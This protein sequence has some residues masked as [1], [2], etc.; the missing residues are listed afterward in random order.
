MIYTEKVGCTGCRYCMPC[1]RGVD[2]PE[3]FLCYNS[4]YTEG[5]WDGRMEFAQNVGLRRQPALATQCIG[6]G[7]CESHCPQHIPIREKLK[8]ADKALR[9]LPFQIGIRITRALKGYQ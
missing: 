2:I 8:E 9:P 1:P 5:K 7:K 6:C 3:T 4:M